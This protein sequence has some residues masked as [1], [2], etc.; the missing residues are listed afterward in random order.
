MR[1]ARKQRPVQ[2][3]LVSACPE[4]TQVIALITSLKQKDA[5]NVAEAFGY[6]KEELSSIPCEANLGLSC[7]NPVATA[8]IKE[9]SQPGTKSSPVNVVL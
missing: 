9:V 3:P 8:S 5:A 1:I 7:G 6:T 4:S 2:I